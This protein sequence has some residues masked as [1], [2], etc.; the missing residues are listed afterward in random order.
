MQQLPTK[1]IAVIGGGSWATALVKILSNNGTS[2]NWWLRNQES[3]EYIKKNKHNPNYLTSV[4]FETENEFETEKL[5]LDSDIKKTIANADILI[6]AVPS[7]FLKEALNGLTSDDFKNKQVFSAIKG[8]V[9]EHNLIVGEFFNTVYKVPIEKIGVITGPCHA[10]EV[11]MEKLSYLTIAC[12]NEVNAASMA[13]QLNCRFIKTTVSDDIYGTEYSAV[14]KNV[15]AIAGGI[16]HGLGYGD[17][18]QAV[19]ISNAIQ[20]IKRFVD[21]VHPIDRDIK[22]SAY[23]GDLLVTAY[24]KF[25]R[26]RTFGSM[27]GKGYSVKSAQMEMNMIAEGYYGVKC[28]YEINKKYKVEMPITNA[29]YAI[30][31]EK[32][33]PAASIQLLTNQLS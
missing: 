6:M 19:L 15:F 32:K 18:F 27:I 10:E 30:L 16:C 31:Y 20:E 4:E 21:T 1:K 13:S 8:I 25:S 11:A 33:S 23:L 9:P 3:V 5:I 28:I 7:A 29:V 26:N 14:L 24:S 22:S 12:Q 17:N 2:I